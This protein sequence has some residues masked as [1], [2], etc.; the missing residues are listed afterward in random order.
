MTDISPAPKG[1]PL[2][3][4][5]MKGNLADVKKFINA[6]PVAG[7]NVLLNE[8][9]TDRYDIQYTPL[10][11]AARSEYFK[12]VEYLIIEGASTATTTNDGWNALHMAAANNNTTTA[13]VEL[14][15][16][17]M[18]LKDI[19]H[20]SINGR[21]PLDACY[22]YNNGVT[23]KQA[24]IKLIRQKGGKRAIKKIIDFTNKANSINEVKSFLGK[25]TIRN[26]RID[27]IK[28]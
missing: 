23:M 7:R 2:V 21:T 19:N 3:V 10:M 14:L 26:N 5:C 13:I 18:T 6:A 28:F 25:L 12:I 16:N 1:T 20:I 15:L 22:A 11:A 17:K 27:V 9:G 8:L 24:I 4:A